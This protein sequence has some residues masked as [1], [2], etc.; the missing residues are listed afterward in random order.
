MLSHSLYF[1]GKK[2]WIIR[3][4]FLLFGCFQGRRYIRR[5]WKSIKKASVVQRQG[6]CLD[7]FSL[8]CA[9]RETEALLLHPGEFIDFSC[10]SVFR[11]NMQNGGMREI[12]VEGGIPRHKRGMF[13]KDL[14]IIY[15]YRSRLSSHFM[16]Q[17][18]ICLEP[19]GIKRES[20]GAKQ[21]KWF[22]S[23]KIYQRKTFSSSHRE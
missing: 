2:K 21:W 17:V 19:S 5:K 9:F 6:K 16:T 12:I 3:T 13:V 4:L 22:R 10:D 8:L 11:V 18:F 1:L 14:L 7:R 15:N 20:V 23:K